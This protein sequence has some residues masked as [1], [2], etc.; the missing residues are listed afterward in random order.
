MVYEFRYGLGYENGNLIKKFK[1]LTA[2][3]WSLELLFNC[4]IKFYLIR[5][6]LN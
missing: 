5:L 6:N 3:T 1:S 2:K 4:R